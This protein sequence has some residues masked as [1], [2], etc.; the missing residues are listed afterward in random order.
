MNTSFVRNIY[1]FGRISV[2]V[3]AVYDIPG[4]YLKYYASP[5][6]RQR[7]RNLGKRNG[8]WGNVSSGV[9]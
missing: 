9:V 6:M 4:N 7:R 2:H 1:A 5:T 8:Y 3:F